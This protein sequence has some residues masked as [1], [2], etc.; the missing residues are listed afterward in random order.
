MSANQPVTDSDGVPRPLKVLSGNIWRLLVVVAGLFA[1]GYV[2]NI[3][4][5]VAFALF[6]ALLVTAWAGP[7]M[8][9]FEKKLPKVVS[10]ILA[11][12]L[13]TAAIVAILSVVVASVIG[14]GPKLVASI[15]SGLSEITEWVR[16]PP[17]SL[18]D[19]QFSTLVTDAQNAGSSVAKGIAGEALSAFGS[20]S[21]VVVAGSVFLFA[22]IFFLLT[23]NQIWNWLLSWI[24]AKGRHH[25]DVSG[26]IFWDS[27]AGYTRGVII[28]AL[29]DAS[30]VF[31][32]LMILQVPLAP[33]LAA[34]V[35]FGAFIPVIGAPIATFFAAVVALAENGPVTALL[36]I[37]LTV[38]VGSFDGDVMQPLV[39]GKAVNLHPLA[40]VI[41]IAVGAI[42]LGIVGALVAV[43]IT[44]AVYGV[45]KY[46]TNRDPSHPYN[47]TAPSSPVPPPAAVTTS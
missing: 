44:G 47:S 4:F 7:V 29:A 28:V 9:F 6:F 37:L 42:A 14:E 38:I 20:L 43:P 12:V 5:A 41:A 25:V 15:Q 18:S 30:L 10:M 45:M 34:V 19:D 1:I 13:I 24:P 22:V 11:L 32:G 16:K 2:L 27:I 40:I 39:M 31:I 21:T 3:L 36:V 8:R 46:V 33:A 35:F 26:Q 23:P 17:L